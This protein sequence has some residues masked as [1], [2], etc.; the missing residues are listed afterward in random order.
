MAA[1]TGGAGVALSAAN[2]TST[3]TEAL[4]DKNPTE[5]NREV[6]FRFRE[7]AQV[8]YVITFCRGGFPSFRCFLHGY[9]GRL[10]REGFSGSI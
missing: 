3:L 10:V 1:V 6:A 8:R 5:L 9:A 4:R 7:S 2:W